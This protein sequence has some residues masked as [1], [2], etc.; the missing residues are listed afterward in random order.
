[1]TSAVSLLVLLAAMPAAAQSPLMHS[2]LLDRLAQSRPAPWLPIPLMPVVAPQVADLATAQL[3]NPSAAARAR[4]AFL[5]GESADPARASAL[6]A[7]LSDPER[8][9]RIHAGIALCRLGHASGRSAA[10]AAL[11]GTPAWV[12]YYA[13]IGLWTLGDRASLCAL[14]SARH[15][16]SPLVA[17]AISA[18]VSRPGR[19]CPIRPSQP[20]LPAFTPASWPE[21]LD[22]AA[23]ALNAESDWW[24]HKGDHEQCV[25]ANQALVFLT[26]DAIEPYSNSAWLLWSMGHHTEAIGEYHRAIDANPASADAAFYLGFYYFQHNLYE[27]AEPY[28]WLAVRL[29]PRDH[30]S[31][32]ILAH[33]LEKQG[34]PAEALQQWEI[35]ARQRPKDGAVLL[36]L[37]RLRREVAAA[38]DP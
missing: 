26:P 22:A 30:L 35:L 29:S 5:L 21:A 6:L 17:R 11:I 4:A 34:R 3:T 2:K 27:Q 32:R 20:P 15:G 24:W 14:E 16:Q 13:V 36:N 28:L 37:R 33:C 25:R 1:M 31:R 23:S 12:R 10:A 19:G 38:E 8:R 9:V 18:A 7:L